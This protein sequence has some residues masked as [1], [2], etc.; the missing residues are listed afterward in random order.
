M[1]SPTAAGSI[2]VIVR[3]VLRRSG[4][5]LLCRNTR[6]GY[7]YLPGGHVEVGEAAAQAL[8]REMREETGWVAEVGGFLFAAEQIFVQD[9]RPRHEINLVLEILSLRPGEG[10][11]DP[12][13][14]P[15]AEEGIAFEWIE[16]ALAVDLD[17][18]PASVRAWL[19]CGGVLESDRPWISERP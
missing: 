17:I 4:A 10:E 5:V 13:A 2:E 1:H 18:R 7:L 14:V 8:A 15:A 12:D 11:A 3:G 9:G 6:R 19:A 16:P